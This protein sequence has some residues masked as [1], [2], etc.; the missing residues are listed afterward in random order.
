MLTG[1]GR[2]SRR[3]D[4]AQGSK[5]K[6]ESEGMSTV[7]DIRFREPV[8]RETETVRVLQETPPTAA[9]EELQDIQGE[10][11]VLNMGPS[12]PSTRGAAHRS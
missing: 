6:G 5:Q 8:A 10:K 3:S 4:H 12:H 1:Q 11:M 9:R 7:Q 2:L